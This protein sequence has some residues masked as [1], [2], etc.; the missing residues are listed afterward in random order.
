MTSANFKDYLDLVTT[1]IDFYKL[2]Q[3]ASPKI[4]E[5][6]ESKLPASTNLEKHLDVQ[7]KSK[8]YDKI[9]RDEK[10]KSVIKAF[11][12]PQE[13]PDLGPEDRKEIESARQAKIRELSEIQRQLEQA[14]QALPSQAQYPR[15]S[16]KKKRKKKHQKGGKGHHGNGEAHSD[17]KFYDLETDELVKMINGGKSEKKMKKSMNRNSSSKPK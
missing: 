3:K 10:I 7:H 6:W 4:I 16:N 5:I 17:P 13:F 14:R 15:N 11:Y 8:F 9:W 12:H 2:F 1:V